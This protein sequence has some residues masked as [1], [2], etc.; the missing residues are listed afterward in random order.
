MKS[1]NLKILITGASGFIGRNL[2]EYLS[3]EYS[4]K[5]TLFY[6]LHAELELL[7]SAKVS[8]FINSNKIDSIIHSASVGGSRK[9][10][11]DM[12]RTDIVYKNLRMFFNL[13]QNLDSKRRMIF[14]GSGVEYNFRHY[15]SGMSEDYFG[16]H[17]PED[18]YGFSKFVCSKSIENCNSIANLRLF[19]VF[20]KYEDYEYRFISN[21][22]VKNLLGLPIVINQNVYFDYLYVNDLVG[23]VE[24]FMNKKTRYKFYNVTTGKTIDLLTIA[25]KINQISDKKSEIIVRNPGLGVEYSGNNKRLLK[26]LGGFCFVPFDKALNELY[27]W[28]KVNLDKIDRKIIAEDRYAQYCRKR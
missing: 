1:N 8:E 10:G 16:V 27:N 15:M 3:K 24:Y 12:D 22:I 18:A 7:D 13:A 17:T 9:T 26:E 11:Y 28:Y 23:I 6:P 5:Y 4:D 14:L 25:N 19:G 21:A 2:I 20:G